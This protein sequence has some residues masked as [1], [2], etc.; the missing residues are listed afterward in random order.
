MSG[1]KM[2]Y[3]S[4]LH[5]VHWY[6]VKIIVVSDRNKKCC[7]ILFPGGGGKG[8]EMWVSR[9]ELEE[10]K[11]QGKFQRLYVSDEMKASLQ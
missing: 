4:N 3:E 6:A 1:R 5:G 7:P 11:N 8:R 9:C 2:E 10:K